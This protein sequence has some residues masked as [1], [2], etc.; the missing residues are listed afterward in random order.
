MAEKPDKDA[1]AE[2]RAV[3]G[4]VEEMLSEIGRA[5]NRLC[6]NCPGW[7]AGLVVCSGAE[8]KEALIASV[9]ESAKEDIRFAHRQ[10]KALPRPNARQ[11]RN[12]RWRRARGSAGP[13]AGS[14]AMRRVL[15]PRWSVCIR[16]LQ[17]CLSR[18]QGCWCSVH[19]CGH[20]TEGEAIDLATAFAMDLA[21]A[22]MILEMG[23]VQ[24]SQPWL[25]AFSAQT[26]G[27][28][29][30]SGECLCGGSEASVVWRGWC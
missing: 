16:H 4:V 5:A 27:Y 22:D 12:S 14:G 6:E 29:G 15:H 18:Q 1:E 24:A 7:T 11:S 17:L 28:P 8:K 25:L 21:G 30:R 19:R 3:R 20:T 26:C 9:P 23:G 13:E 10:V 2:D